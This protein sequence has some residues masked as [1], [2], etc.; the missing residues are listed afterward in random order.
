MKPMSGSGPAAPFSTALFSSPSIPSQHKTPQCYSMF[1]L[2]QL[3]FSLWELSIHYFLKKCDRGTMSSSII[4]LNKKPSLML[5]L[6]ILSDIL[7]A[8]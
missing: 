1:T 3:S 2:H 4:P 5:K 6:K 8:N 7:K